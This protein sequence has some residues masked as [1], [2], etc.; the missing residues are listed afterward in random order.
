MWE[1]LA[2]VG[3]FLVKL[4]QGQGQWWA[5]Q[6]WFPRKGKAQAQETPS[7]GGLTWKGPA[8]C[9]PGQPREGPQAPELN[10][11]DFLGHLN[12]QEPLQVTVA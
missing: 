11:P 2:P 1:D 8:V 6:E 10:S 3:H 9:A 12:I 5:A 4:G 7:P